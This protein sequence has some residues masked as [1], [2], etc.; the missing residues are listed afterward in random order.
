MD[1]NDLTKICNVE[2]IKPNVINKFNI[3]GVNVIVL[4][5]NNEYYVTN[6]TCPHKGAD[7]A[8]GTIQ[9]K[10]IVKCP[11]HYAEYDLK[12]DNT[13]KGP[14][15]S[16]IKLVNSLVKG[17]IPKLHKYE[18]ILKGNELYIKGNTVEQKIFM[19]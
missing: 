2:E 18:T 4:N 1:T 12:N 3:N 5:V 7:L 19:K 17:I 14:Q 16:K 13:V 15:I 8:K 6:G 11:W 9:D 10:C